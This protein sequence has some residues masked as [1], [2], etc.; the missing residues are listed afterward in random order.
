MSDSVDSYPLQVPGVAGRGQFQDVVSP[1]SGEVIARVEQADSNAVEAAMQLS[2]DTFARER[3]S[4][5]PPTVAPPS[6]RILRLR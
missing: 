2:A 6:W 3:T 1:Y 5:L 4:M